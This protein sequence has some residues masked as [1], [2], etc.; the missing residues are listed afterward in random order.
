MRNNPE[1]AALRDI[2]YWF[3]YAMVSYPHIY[4]EEDS[5]PYTSAAGRL[6]WQYDRSQN[7]FK[8]WHAGLT[9]KLTPYV[10]ACFLPT[11]QISSWGR[12]DCRDQQRV[13]VFRISFKC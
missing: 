5:G 11:Q 9:R 7:V 4:P 3:K 12:C 2:C 1:Y 8:V 10:L 6:E 13:W